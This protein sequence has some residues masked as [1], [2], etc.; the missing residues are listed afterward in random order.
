MKPG[1]QSRQKMEIMESHRIR[2]TEAITNG[3]LY[4]TKMILTDVTNLNYL[5]GEG[6]SPLM[7]AFMLEDSKHRTRSAM[8]KLLLQHKADVNLR[9]KN[10][11]HVLNL[12]CKMNKFDLVNLLLTRCLQ[13]VELTS[14]DHNG[15]TPLIYAVINNN[16]NMVK[17]LVNVLKKFSLS[18]DQ[19]NN[20]DKTAYL[21]ALELGFNECASILSQVGKASQDIKVN[22]FQDFLPVPNTGS[23]GQFRVRS[24]PLPKQFTTR[25]NP[26]VNGS[27]FDGKQ[28]YFTQNK[29]QTNKPFK[30]RKLHSIVSQNS[31]HEKSKT[32][33]KSANVGWNSHVNIKVLVEDNVLNLK[34]GGAALGKNEA[35][36]NLRTS[37]KDSAEKKKDPLLRLLLGQSPSRSSS[38][39]SSPRSSVSHNS[40]NEIVKAQSKAVVP[41]SPGNT[42]IVSNGTNGCNIG[43]QVRFTIAYIFLIGL[44]PIK[45]HDPHCFLTDYKQK[46]W[47]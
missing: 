28:T 17:L 21:K 13:D 9:D 25:K 39:Q 8:V 46:I 31:K 7:R 44:R 1:R 47:T 24:A 12:A 33:P 3:R 20:Q 35:S 23:S 32:K 45:D 36:K 29:K 4:Q 16:A 26:C 22:P 42:L 18:V 2:L 38:V 5:D 10:G 30:S 27:L 19:R 43:K 6:M 15:N 40:C 41:T 37:R 34:Q 14:Q 11:Q